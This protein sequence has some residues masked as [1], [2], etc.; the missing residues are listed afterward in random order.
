MVVSST[1]IRT[2]AHSRYSDNQ[3]LRPSM[4]VLISGPLRSATPSRTATAGFDHPVRFPPALRGRARRAGSPQPG[5]VPADVG[6]VLVRQRL[7][8][9]AHRAVDIR[10]LAGLEAAQLLD[11]V[12]ELQTR[13]AR[14]LVLSGEGRGM[15][16]IAVISGHDGLA[17]LG[18]DLAG[19]VRAGRLLLQ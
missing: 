19:R 17:R 10:T 3:R 14:N 9:F 6:D 4:R 2:P 15:A 11:Q 7:S 18:S 8:G 12:V 5:Q 13:Q 16:G 1:I